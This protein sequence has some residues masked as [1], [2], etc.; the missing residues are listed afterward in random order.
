MS[1]SFIDFSPQAAWYLNPSGLSWLARSQ[2][3]SVGATSSLSAK[4][5]VRGSGATSATTALRVENT[6]ASASLVVLDNGS[7]YS[8]GPKFITSNTAF[9][10]GA[11]SALD[12]GS[13]N[14]AFGV[15][16]HLFLTNGRNN[17]GVG[18]NANRSITIADNNTAVG[19]HALYANISASGNT[20]VGSNAL[21][22][23]TATN[24]TAIGTVSSFNTTIGGF[25]TALGY[26][27]LYSN[28]NGGSNTAI[29]YATLYTLNTGSGNT[30]VGINAGRYVAPST[31]PLSSSN[32]SVFL[33][34]NTRANSDGE[35]NQIVI[36]YD[37][38]G[39]GSNTVVLG[40]SS[41]TRTALRGN[42][43][44]GTTT[45]S[46][47]LH[48][49]GA[50]SATLLEIDSPAINNIIFV[51]GSG[52][53][54]VGTGTPT[55][56][57]SVVDSSGYSPSLNAT[58][59]ANF[60]VA[61]GVT[62]ATDLVF[63]LSGSSPFTAAIQHRHASLNGFSYPISLNPL[64][65]N[66]G[67]GTF[68]PSTTFNVN[69]TTF[70][71]GG[72]T[73]VRG[74]GATSATTALLV[75]NA[76]ASASLVIL[77]NGNIG[78]RTSSPTSFLDIRGTQT[79]PGTF[80]RIANISTIISASANNDTLIGL[81]IQPT[82]HTGAF[83]GVSTYAIRANGSIYSSGFL[84][85]AG[86]V[87]NTS[88]VLS[89][90]GS[91][92]VSIT[93]NSTGGEKLR[94]F[95]STG[96]VL[97]QNG[98]TFTDA[99]YRLDISGSGRFTNGLIVSSSLLAFSGSVSSIDSSNRILSDNTG[100]N[101]LNWDASNNGYAVEV[102]RAYFKSTPDINAQEKF[103]LG[104]FNAEGRILEGVNFNGASDYDYV[105]LDR[106]AGE[107]MP[108]DNV[109]DKATKM[110]GIAFEVGGANK[111]LL[112]GSVTIT[113]TPGIYS[114]PAVDVIEHGLPIY[115]S[116]STYATTV[117]P[118]SSGEYVRIL[119]HAYYQNTSD[120]DVWVMDF[121]PDH[122]WRQL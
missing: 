35:T 98:G 16:A 85:G 93:T 19:Y 21:T 90:A 120:P 79:S 92:N 33:G 105:Y 22:A 39:L 107:W 11:H 23:N 96:N 81:D 87:G 40:N 117:P 111:V 73:T 26:A 37:A 52:R 110:L 54:G 9:G 51:S 76:N 67:I 7:V 42:V 114:I 78:I 103:S 41:I 15:N 64:G 57:L 71:Q 84:F 30:A 25:N 104:V 6:N 88:L 36:G 113:T 31:S 45:P 27:S 3:L 13:N 18:L 44:I 108:V 101:T 121:R 106:S 12:S 109:T 122:Y 14:T 68:L 28:V 66:V 17:V 34:Q 46:A 97:I 56:R 49:S 74:S 5:G 95:G 83:T 112:N 58:A 91:N 60:N 69:G 47:S 61:R 72:Q 94:V 119:G 43:G 99:G 48:I 100:T 77:D 65:G 102:S 2:N 10:A 8:F 38:N 62:F 82:Y 20:A 55:S 116:S 24:N 29:G 75:E 32:F 63:T 70:L 115:V 1:G 118:A 86:V 59:S 4:L 89:S 53:V 50:S 80:T